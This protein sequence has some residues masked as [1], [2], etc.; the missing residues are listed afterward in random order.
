MCVGMRHKKNDKVNIF[1]EF[2]RIRLK[3]KKKELSFMSLRT[4][5]VE[6][7]ISCTDNMFSTIAS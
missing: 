7:F 1:Y 6:R 3:G 2:S 4:S 5:V